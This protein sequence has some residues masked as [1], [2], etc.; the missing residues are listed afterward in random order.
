MNSQ[1]AS[2]LLIIMTLT[3]VLN[4]IQTYTIADPLCIVWISLHEHIT[5][6][7]RADDVRCFKLALMC[8]M[9]YWSAVFGVFIF[10]SCRIFGLSFDNVI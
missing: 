7:E 4:V 3:I 9:A 1:S 8:I 2:L 5:A 6:W 10:I